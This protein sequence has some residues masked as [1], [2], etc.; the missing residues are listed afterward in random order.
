MTN[1]IRLAIPSWLANQIDPGTQLF[2]RKIED[3]FL[4]VM[5]APPNQQ[6]GWHLS[7]S[8]N[9]LISGPNGETVPGRYPSWDEIVEARYEFLP[10]EIHVA[11]ILPPRA[12]YINVHNT[13]F[14]LHECD[15][16]RPVIAIKEAP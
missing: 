12:E 2:D 4:R 14:H 11:M 9:S 10:G 7:I 13:C 15:V 6:T 1:W 3:G 8:H 16:D 5:V